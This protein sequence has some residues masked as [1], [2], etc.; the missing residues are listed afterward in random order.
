[1]FSIRKDDVNN[2]APDPIPSSC[3]L[4]SRGPLLP[5]PITLFLPPTPFLFSSFFSLLI[6]P[7]QSHLSVFPQFFMEHPKQ[8]DSD[9]KPPISTPDNTPK[10]DP[11]DGPHAPNGDGNWANFVM[12]SENQIPT[13]N[14]QPVISTPS[15][16]TVRWSTELVTESPSVASNSYGS[17]T[18]TYAASSPSS[19]SSSV[20]FKGIVSLGLICA[21]V[22]FICICRFLWWILSSCGIKKISMH[23]DQRRWILCGAR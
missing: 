14:E 2:T 3:A 10:S 7:S 20:S 15:K 5:L 23:F 22:S 21:S 11:K 9:N 4:K 19:P 17:N 16:K 8:Q 12:G 6:Y 18:N 1:M 13:Q